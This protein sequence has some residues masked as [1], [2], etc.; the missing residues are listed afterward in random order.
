MAPPKKAGGKGKGKGG[1][2]QFGN[3]K[4]PTKGGLGKK[5]GKGKGK[6]KDAPK[7]VKVLDPP[8]KRK[9]ESTED[10][11]EGSKSGKANASTKVAQKK[12][13]TSLYT[14]LINAGRERKAEEVVADILSVLSNRKEPLQD[15]S[16][17]RIG[18]RVLQACLKWGSQEQRK[19]LLASLQDS[20]EVFLYIAKTTAQR[21]PTE[22][23]K[24]VQKQNLKQFMNAFRDKNISTIFFHRHGCKVINALYFSEHLP[25]QEKRQLLHQVFVPQ[26]IALVKPEL[27]GSKPLRGILSSEELSDT[28]KESILSHLGDLL[29]RA[30][31]KELLAYDIVHLAFQT[32]C[33]FAS[34]ER[35]K[36]LAE[37][38][39]EGGPYLLS[40]RPGAEALL[41]LL[42]YCS[43]KQKKPFLKDLKGK[44]AALAMNTVDYLIPMRLCSIVDDTKALSDGMLSEWKA[45]MKELCFDKH[46]HK[47]LAWLLKPGDKHFFAPYELESLSLPAP[48]SLKEPE[49]RQQ[50]LLKAIRPSIQAV[51]LADPVKAM[52]SDSARELFIAYLDSE[53]DS[54]LVAAL[55]AE[56]MGALNTGVFVA[57]MLTLLRRESK[58]VDTDL[59]LPFWQKVLSPRLEKAVTTRCSFIMSALLKR[60]GKVAEETLKTL[61]SKK[62][63][64]EQA[65][66][67]AKSSGAQVQG[68]QK[69]LDS[70]D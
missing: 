52:S 25:T 28:Q 2:K 16:S 54:Q 13:V 47:V 62:R 3:K 56:E 26:T 9:I 23:E 20:D 18:S 53:W 22:E 61:K 19:Q 67:A 60:K 24:K 43:A 40:S 10:G 21:K 14:E 50:E 57:G 46:G 36:D 38:C 45:E 65:V 39:I 66:K 34:A 69:L 70:L 64:V 32:Y 55:I 8:K 6:G 15:Y 35:L 68:A 42:G 27:V 44:Y 30:I 63:T 51:L 58:S 37:K 49:K 7:V 4:K 59:A 11:E 29:D 33:E 5:A 48:T 41:R 17:K 31:D 12:E 1:Q